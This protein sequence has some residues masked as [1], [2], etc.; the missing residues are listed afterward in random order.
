MTPNPKTP[1]LLDF[2]HGTSLRIE[3]TLPQSEVT[4]HDILPAI[5]TMADAVHA[6]SIEDLT[7]MNKTIGCGPGC[8]ECCHQLVP[9]S[10]HEAAHLAGVVRKMPT[11][12][13]SRVIHRFTQ[14][15]RLLDQSGLMT[16]LNETY[17][18]DILNKE[19]ILE[20]KKQYW[21]LRIPCP[22]LEEDSCSIHKERPLVCRQYLV[23]SAPKHCSHIY[24]SNEAHEVVLH[25]VD[26]GGALAAFSGAGLQESRVVPHIFSLLAERSIRSKPLPLLHASQMMGRYLNLLADCFSR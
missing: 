13:R 10:E 8:S 21:N 23:T 17:A 7:A 12:Q 22:F 16:P 5:F 18:R 26:A 9:V 11:A 2:G 6:Q 15:I 25:T 1:F 20:L 14:A 4:V 24:S 3:L 19:K